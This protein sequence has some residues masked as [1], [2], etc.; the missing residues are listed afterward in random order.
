MAKSS[1]SGKMMRRRV[2]FFIML[3][4]V[5][6]LG[7][8]FFTSLAQLSRLRAEY[9]AL[10]EQDAQADVEISLLEEELEYSKTENFIRRMARELLGWVEPGDTKIVD[11]SQE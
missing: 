7:I 2:T 9:R 3:A 11:D 4:V 10:Q 8:A 5:L 6:A 1:T